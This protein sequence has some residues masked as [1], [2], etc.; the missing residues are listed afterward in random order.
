MR[1]AL[2]SVSREPALD[3]PV[4]DGLEA[5]PSDVELERRILQQTRRT[6]RLR[7][8][9]GRLAAVLLAKKAWNHLG[10]V[11]LGDYTRER[12]GLAGRTLEDDARIA[13]ALERLPLT[14]DALFSSSLSW[15]QVRLITAV[16][17][18][19]DEREWIA[20]AQGGDTRALET[21]VRACA[22]ASQRATL[23]SSPPATDGEDRVERFSVR[24]SRDTRRLWRAA[25]E[26]AERSAGSILTQAQVLELVAAEAASGAPRSPDGPDALDGSL[27]C[28]QES[29]ATETDCIELPRAN[30]QHH[31]PQLAALLESLRIDPPVDARAEWAL[32]RGP[33]IDRDP[34]LTKFLA[35]I[36]A[37]QRARDGQAQTSDGGRDDRDIDRNPAADIHRLL[38]DLSKHHD[39]IARDEDLAALILPRRGSTP[40]ERLEAMFDEADA[41]EPFALDARLR[42]VG[43]AMQRIDAALGRLL[44][45]A[46]ERRLHRRFGF[47]KFTDYVD[48]RLDFCSRKAWSLIAIDRAS[49]R[50]CSELA[51]AYREGRLS[52]LAAAIL[53][54]VMGSRHGRAW[55]ERAGL[56]TLR[57]L[58]SEVSWALDGRDAATGDAAFDAPAPPPLDHDLGHGMLSV[59]DRDRVQMRAWSETPSPAA[60]GEQIA[61]RGETPM[62]AVDGVQNR[63]PYATAGARVELHF[64]A[65]SS[66]SRLAEDTMLVLRRGSESRGEAFARMIATVLLEWISA[67]AHRDPVF[68]RDGWRC[69]VPGC[70]SRRNLHD[71]HVMFRSHGGDNARDNRVAVCAAH[72]LHGLHS[73]RIRARGRAPRE[74]VWELGCRW[75][76]AEPLARLMGDR[77]LAR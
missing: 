49:A 51:V 72:H 21:Q 5:E 77:Y 30:G 48:A 38:R 18:A 66:V 35:E 24:V 60:D 75:N 57:R 67:P 4:L 39:D 12:L 76:G 45:V 63:A 58:E 32:A 52:H 1:I 25:C 56:V 17:R 65:P 36:E 9:R 47:A 43:L 14:A 20:I 50:S 23:A 74:I 8:V 42:E 31:D 2:R 27:S 46:L 33:Q 22:S 16:A 53:L 70:R 59:L 73:G 55:I 29:P 44:R 71:H 64:L 40:V 34:Q 26:M 3:R 7:F 11:R 41:R 28:K 37:E 13:R 54:P 68:A 61:T 10:F 15:T 19:G 69:A 62:S 6:S